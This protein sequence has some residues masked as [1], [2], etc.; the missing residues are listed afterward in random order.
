MASRAERALSFGTIASDYD[1]VRPGPAPAAVDWLLPAA[2]DVVVDLGAG[3]GLLARAL[4]GR[5]GASAAGASADGGSAAGASA[6]GASADGASADG[7]SP[8]GAAACG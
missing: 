6:D 8:R 5:A 3:T 1:R 7:A 2:C 4:T